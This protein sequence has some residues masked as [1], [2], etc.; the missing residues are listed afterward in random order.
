MDLLRPIRAFDRKQQRHRWLAIP[1]AV[2]K[3][4][5]DD[6]AG[7]LAALLAY[8]AFFSLFPLLLVFVT[9]LGYVFQG[10]KSFERTIENSVLAHFPIIG[11]SI[12]SHRFTGEVAAVV[13]GGLAS[14]WAGLGVTQAAQNAFDRI[15][16]VPFKARPDF[17]R[18]RI[19][20]LV[21]LGVLGTLFIV[22]S[23]MSGLV[24]GG[25]GSLGIKTGGIGVSLL[26]NLA[27][28]AA[29]FRLLTTGGVP[30][31]SIWIGA[32]IGGIFW[33]ILQVGGGLYVNHVIRHASNTYGVFATVLGLLA[34]LHVG[35]LG[36][37][38]AAEINVVLVRRLWPRSLF[39]AP[40]EPADEAALRALAKVE[41]R[42]EHERI[43]VEFRT[44]ARSGDSDES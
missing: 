1:L 34:W 40:S 27:L 10:D 39:G 12:R 13:I 24:S 44:Q 19:R 30:V 41:E 7:A 8:Y 35:A 9:V 2:V 29:T 5:S 6:G 23:A 25:L 36:T 21:L 11:T 4:F 16:A 15:W 20:G 3:K 14:L 33:E 22:S 38:Y 18:K 42:S 26:L 32:L 37:L 17:L 28:F 43:E 31:R